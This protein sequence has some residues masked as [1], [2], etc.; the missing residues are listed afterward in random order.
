MSEFVCKV[1]VSSNTWFSKDTLHAEKTFRVLRKTSKVGDV[2]GDECAN[3]GAED[4]LRALTKN[5][6]MKDGIYNLNATYYRDYESGMIDDIEYELTEEA[7]SAIVKKYGMGSMYER[8][9][10]LNAEAV[11]E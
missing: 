5:I 6:D 3:C 10:R 11:E 9:M 7:A 2:I 1:R 4:A 8:L